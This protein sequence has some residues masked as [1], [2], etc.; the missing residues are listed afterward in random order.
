MRIELLDQRLQARDRGGQIRP[1]GDEM[2]IARRQFLEFR[3][4]LDIHVPK[5]GDFR[6]QVFDLRLDRFPVLLL[7]L[8][9]GVAFGQVEF[10]LLAH[11]CDQR[12]APHRVFAQAHL[13]LVQHAL[14]GLDA[15]L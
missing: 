5:P 1:L 2:L 3:D 12:L 4:R 9:T 15:L 13:L 14:R 10:E 8:V 11:A 7:M 6:P